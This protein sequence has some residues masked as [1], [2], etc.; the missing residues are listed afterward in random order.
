MKLKKISSN[1]RKFCQ[2]EEN[3]FKNCPNMFRLVQTYSNLSKHVQMCPNMFRLV[4]TCSNLSKH[5]QLVQNFS[6]LSGHILTCSNMFRL[7]TFGY[8]AASLKTWY[9]WYTWNFA[10]CQLEENFF[11]L[12]GWR[13][14]LQVEENLVILKKNSSTSQIEENFFKLKKTY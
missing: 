2:L 1:W 11:N 3:L 5:V 7:K 10:T 12:W 4:Q 13:K 8:A 6:D 14:F 9:I